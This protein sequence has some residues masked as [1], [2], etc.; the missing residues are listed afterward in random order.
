MSAKTAMKAGF[1]GLG[2]MGAAMAESLLRAGLELT[3]YNR[4]P[5]KAKPLAAKGAGLARKVE[6]ACHGD[7]VITMLSDDS[8]VED[9]VFGAGGVLQSLGRR[10][11]HISMSTISAALSER[12]SAAH[13][14]AGQRF[15]SAPVFG[16]PDMAAAGKLFII[17]SGPSDVLD[18]CEPIF[19]AMG[20]NTIRMGGLPQ[21]ANI[22]KL[23]GNFII[24]SVI[25]ALGEA[26][27][28]IAKAG[29]DRQRYLEMLTS[30]L[31]TGPLFENYGKLIATQ[32][33]H[34]AAFSATLGE[35]DIRLALAAAETLRVPMPL[36]SLLHDRL[37][38]LIARSGERLDWSGLGQLA[39]EDAGLA[40]HG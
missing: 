27:A 21:D 2:R 34:P 16:R 12:L 4:T 32:K 28:L 1:I 17:A 18:A 38:T 37:L 22:V 24:A 15:V 40:R 29:I 11:I 5:E 10:A 23:S 39:A 8:A 26:M 6:D 20:Q 14:A 30:T 33:F 25:E 7:A 19:A 3:V 31:F 13:A 9:A 35:K 36:A